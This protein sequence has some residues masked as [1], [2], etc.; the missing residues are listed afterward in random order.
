M[1]GRERLFP[2]PPLD[3]V[4]RKFLSVLEALCNQN[5]LWDHDYQELPSDL[6]P[7]AYLSLLGFQLCLAVLEALYTPVVPL[8]PGTLN[9]HYLQHPHKLEDLDPDPPQD[10]DPPFLHL[11]QHNQDL[12]KSLG[13]E[14]YSSVQVYL[15]V[16]Y[17]LE[18]L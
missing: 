17:H 18:V 10:Q 8:A 11:D 12:H 5:H 7:L 16:H 4:A 13:L 9:H 2:F 15:E 3:L 6:D 1:W 14:L